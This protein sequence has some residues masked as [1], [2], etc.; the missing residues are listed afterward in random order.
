MIGD[1]FNEV[2]QSI[3]GIDSL[4]P[5]RSVLADLH[6]RSNSFRRFPSGSSPG[7]FGNFRGERAARYGSEMFTYVR[8]CSLMFGYVRINGEKL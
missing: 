7:F 5:A 1:W 6:L 4:A 3:E 2:N 8:L